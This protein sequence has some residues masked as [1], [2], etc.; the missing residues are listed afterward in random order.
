MF[1]NLLLYWGSVSNLAMMKVSRG[2][3]NSAATTSLLRHEEVKALIRYDKVTFEHFRLSHS[4]Y[5]DSAMAKASRRAL[6]LAMVKLRQRVFDLA[7]LQVSKTHTKGI[8]GR[9]NQ[10]KQGGSK[11]GRGLLLPL[12]VAK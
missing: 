1:E 4:D 12:Y 5:S 2:A 11:Q 7:K 10:P 3:F 8:V 6:D 9:P